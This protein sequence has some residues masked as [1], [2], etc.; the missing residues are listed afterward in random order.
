MMAG[1]ATDAVGAMA[2]GAMAVVTMVDATTADTMV[3]DTMV[4]DTMVAAGQAAANIVNVRGVNFQIDIGKL[5]AIRQRKN[6][7]QSNAGTT[8]TSQDVACVR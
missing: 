1:A 4:A 8:D 6:V 7:T 3:A 5:T 2:V